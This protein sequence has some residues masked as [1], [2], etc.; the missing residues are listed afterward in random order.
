MPGV[1]LRVRPREAIRI[2]C[3][4]CQQNF[5][6]DVPTELRIARAIHLA[7]AARAKRRRDFICAEASARSERHG[8]WLRLWEM[9]Q[10]EWISNRKRRSVYGIYGIGLP[11]MTAVNSD[12]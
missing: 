3:N 6:R 1:A 11:S 12:F 2:G 8:K 4:G 5:D 9:G 10:F 7:H